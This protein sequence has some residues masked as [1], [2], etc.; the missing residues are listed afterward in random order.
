MLHAATITPIVIPAAQGTIPEDTHPAIPVS[1]D[2]E[3]AER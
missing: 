2:V 1:G 3:T